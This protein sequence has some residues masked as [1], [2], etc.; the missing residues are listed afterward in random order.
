MTDPYYINQRCKILT[1]NIVNIGI[2]PFNDLNLLKVGMREYDFT[3][4][5]N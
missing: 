1:S 5:N 2:V 4:L 3:C